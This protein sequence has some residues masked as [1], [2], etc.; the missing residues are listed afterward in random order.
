MEDIDGKVAVITGGASGIGLGMARALGGA[1]MRLV[2]A[3]IEA[4]AL[5]AAAGE[6]RESGFTVLEVECDVANKASV[7]ELAD[8]T[9]AE[10]GGAHVL[11][12][13]AGVVAQHAAWDELDTWDWV[14]GV[15]LMGVIY[16][17][18][19]FVPRMLESGEPGHIVN[20]ASV[21]GL[22][23]FPN[24]ASYNVA[25][26]GVVALSETM[27]LEL[28]DKPLGVSVLCPGLVT[29]NINNSARNRP[30]A[31]AAPSAAPPDSAAAAEALSAD[32]VGDM[33][34][35]AVRDEVFWVLP[36]PHYADQAVNLAEG[37]RSGQA[38]GAPA[39]D[40]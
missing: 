5:H 8:R 24:I 15:D 25:K 19:A 18:H 4:P 29:T 9:W 7:E 13:N 32:H 14:L 38:P 34:L 6:L 31:A 12:N 33:V 20:T 22:L 10:F 39:I 2:L 23:S 27:H 37:R 40:R 1:G 11:A 21:A 35:Q 30:G 28:Q 26:H 17:V 36:H 16:G 3:D